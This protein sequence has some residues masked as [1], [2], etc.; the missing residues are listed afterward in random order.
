MKQTLREWMLEHAPD[1]LA[2]LEQAKGIRAARRAQY[3]EGYPDADLKPL[4][5]T[6]WL[7]LATMPEWRSRTKVG[8]DNE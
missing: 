4:E 5:E 8:G 6:A 1:A 2:M 3:G 7:L